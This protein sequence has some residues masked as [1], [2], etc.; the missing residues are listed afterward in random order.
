MR[1]LGLA[2]AV[3]GR[4]FTLTTIPDAAAARPAD[5]V[6]RQ[7]T[8]VRPNQVWVA[9][10]TYVATWRG[11]VY[12]A[13]V[14][15]VFSLRMVGWRRRPHRAATWRSMRWSRRS[16][17]ARSSRR[18]RWCTTAIGACSTCRSSTRNGSP[19]PASSRRSKHGGL[20]RQRAGG[21]GDRVVQ[22]GGDPSS[23][24]VEG[25]R[26]RRVRDARVGRTVQR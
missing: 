5:L 3:R 24:T 20:V 1:R 17:I 23:R 12:V 4:K 8:A 26:G 7:F 25:A 13:F 6:T 21:N 11:F 16:T 19:R 14:I 10:L 22:D 2:C 18:S 9:H 15:D